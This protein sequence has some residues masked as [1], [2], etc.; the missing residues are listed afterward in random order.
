M[1][2]LL[3]QLLGQNPTGLLLLHVLGIVQCHAALATNVV[4]VQQ[5]LKHVHQGSYLLL[6]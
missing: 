4:V 6:G 1:I 3:N 5:G 2:Y